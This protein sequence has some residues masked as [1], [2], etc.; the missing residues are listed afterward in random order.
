MLYVGYKI[1]RKKEAELLL[2]IDYKGKILNQ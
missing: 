2:A 1:V